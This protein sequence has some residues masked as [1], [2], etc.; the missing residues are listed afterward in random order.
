VAAFTPSGSGGIPQSVR[1][2]GLTNPPVIQTITI[3]N[4]NTEQSVSLPSSVRRYEIQVYSLGHLKVAH[5]SGA[6]STDY[7]EIGKG[8]YLV[9][10]EIEPAGPITLYVQSSATGVVARVRYWT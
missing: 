1:V 6:S 4:S 9:D 2:T 8:C 10:D 5:T 7:L 3:T